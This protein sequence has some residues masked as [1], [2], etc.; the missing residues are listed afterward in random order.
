M[1]VVSHEM[2]RKIIIMSKSGLFK[3]GHKHS[4]KDI[5]SLLE[6][7]EEKQGGNWNTG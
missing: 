6:V 7:F 5:N 4:R 1:E 3:V 2:R